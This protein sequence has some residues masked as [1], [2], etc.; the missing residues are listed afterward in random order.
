[1]SSFRTCC[2]H[3]EYQRDR[4]GQAPPAGGLHF[5][6]RS[7][8]SREGIELRVAAGVGLR[9]L[10]GEQTAIFEPM[11]RGIQRPLGDLDDVARYLLKP[12]CDGVAVNRAKRDEFQDQQ[13]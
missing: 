11:E 10:G 5:E 3:P 4:V 1:T 6:L 12:L 13:V 7:A 8:F 2:R 9:P